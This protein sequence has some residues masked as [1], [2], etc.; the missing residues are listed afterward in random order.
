M[1]CPRRRLRNCMTAAAMPAKNTNRKNFLFFPPFFFS[2]PMLP[3]LLA[4]TSGCFLPGGRRPPV[5]RRTRPGPAYSGP[6]TGGKV[7]RREPGQRWSAPLGERDLDPADQVRD[8]VVHERDQQRDQRPEHHHDHAH[9]ER[10]GQQPPPV[11]LEV[12]PEPEVPQELGRRIQHSHGRQ[13]VVQDGQPQQDHQ[14]HAEVEQQRELE[15]RP[16]ADLLHDHPGPPDLGSPLGTRGRGDLD[17]TGHAHPFTTPTGRRRATTRDSPAPSQTETTS[18][19]SLY[20]Y[21]A[22]SASNRGCDA[23][24]AIPCSRSVSATAGPDMT[25]LAWVLDMARPAPWQVEEK[26]RPAASAAPTR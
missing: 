19:T 7:E 12:L 23:A 22:S 14:H 10:P 25:F 17:R 1:P 8:E 15:D 24:T 21:G 16:G 11:E 6:R 20:A 26:L 9:G 13:H 18:E 4:A 2:S 3:L 5:K